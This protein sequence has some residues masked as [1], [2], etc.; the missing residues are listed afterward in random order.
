MDPSKNC[1]CLA[2]F[3]RHSASCCAARWP[4]TSK[5]LRHTTWLDQNICWIMESKYSDPPTNHWIESLKICL[6]NI[7]FGVTFLVFTST[8]FKRAIDI[9][10]DYFFFSCSM[11]DLFGSSRTRKMDAWPAHLNGSTT[12]GHVDHQINISTRHSDCWKKPCSKNIQTNSPNDSV[13]LSTAWNPLPWSRVASTL[14]SSPRQ[15]AENWQILR[16]QNCKSFNSTCATFSTFSKANAMTIQ[17]CS[18]FWTIHRLTNWIKKCK[19]V[20]KHYMFQN[21][22]Q[23]WCLYQPDGTTRVPTNAGLDLYEARSH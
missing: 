8:S 4:G 16:W 5:P 20:L 15:I 6:G 21:N 12:W 7:G 19:I 23:I 14:R 1:C 18:T 9:K 11:I 17:R 22:T 10:L 13:E 3:P 2:T